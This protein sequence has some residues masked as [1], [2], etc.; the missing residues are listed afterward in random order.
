MCVKALSSQTRPLPSHCTHTAEGRT[1]TS[2]LTDIMHEIEI[3]LMFS[4]DCHSYVKWFRSKEL[5]SYRRSTSK[6]QMLFFLLKLQIF[7]RL[8]THLQPPIHVF[9]IHLYSI[10]STFKLVKLKE[11][12]FILYIVNR[13]IG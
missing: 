8:M 9:P 2:T 6:Y 1:R 12:K 7:I 11:T 4:K 13:D 5:T 10:L 3:S